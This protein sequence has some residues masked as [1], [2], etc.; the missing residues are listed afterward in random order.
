[1]LISKFIAAPEIGEFVSLIDEHQKLGWEL[2]K[3]K[4]AIMIGWLFHVEMFRDDGIIDPVKQSRQ[5]ILAKARAAKAAKQE[6]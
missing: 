5:E 1:M 2:D 3:K 4:P 6:K